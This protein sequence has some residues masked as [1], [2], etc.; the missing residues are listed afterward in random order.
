MTEFNQSFQS[1]NEK[2]QQYMQQQQKCL[3]DGFSNILQETFANIVSQNDLNMS[4]SQNQIQHINLAAAELQTVENNNYSQI[5]SHGDQFQ[6]NCNL[7]F[8][9]T[10][11]Q[12]T[13][14]GKVFTCKL[15]IICDSENSRQQHENCEDEIGI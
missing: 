3:L 14:V 7:Q 13:N 4:E 5:S 15:E 9:E 12:A 2:H 8:A 6:V 1:K 10:K 11:S